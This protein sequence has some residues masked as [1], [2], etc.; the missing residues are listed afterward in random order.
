MSVQDVATSEEIKACCAV[1]YG[2][3]WMRFLIGDS[4]H[5]GGVELT[6][7]MGRLL[8]LGPES[9]VLDVAAGRGVSAVALAQRFGCQVIGIDLSQDIIAAAREE[10][11]RAGVDQLA[12]FEVADA[13]ALPFAEAQFD[14]LICECAFCTFPDKPRV[15]NEMARV[16]KP[17]GRVGIS[18]L[19]QRAGLPQELLTLAGWVACIADARPQS[20]YLTLFED[21]GFVQPVVEIHDDAL[22]QLVDQ[23]RRRLFG[24][25]LMSRLGH[26]DLSGIDLAQAA[27]IGRA[28]QSA[29]RNGVLG[30]IVLTALKP[31]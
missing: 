31:H 8:E 5:P 26:L 9:R 17:G 6:E 1:V 4:M 24:V 10:A 16:L 3:D 27:A 7:R 21:A 30:Y 25:G 11:R 12:S 18:D 29:A 2:S 22:T 20:D 28:A 23:I 13:D 19:V 15:A 14:A